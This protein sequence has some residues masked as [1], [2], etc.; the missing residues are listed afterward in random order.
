MVFSSY[1]FLFFFLPIVCGAY[2]ILPARARNGF[3]LIASLFFYGWNKPLLLV[4]LMFSIAVNYC[5]GR[6]VAA[7]G[8]FKKV[9]LIA[10]IVINIVLLL[11]YKYSNFIVRSLC[12]LFPEIAAKW[13]PVV[14]P[15]GISFFTFQ[16]MSYTI[17]VYR[18][19][20]KALKNPLDV[21]LYISLF[22]QL[23]AGPIVRFKSIAEEIHNRTS[24][25][26][27]IGCGFRRFVYGLS[28]K[29]ILADTFGKIADEIFSAPNSWNLGSAWIGILAYTFQIYYDFSGYSDM[30][31]G[32]GSVFGFHFGENFNFPYI[33][34][35]ITEFWHRW[36]ISLST[37]F[38]DYVYIPLGGSRVTTRRHIFNIMVVWLLTG[39]WHGADWSFI[40]WGIYYG[41]LLLV[42]KYIIKNRFSIIK[43][44]GWMSTILLV[45][46]G[47][48]LFRADTLPHAIEYL[49]IMFSFK[50]TH[51]GYIIFMRRLVN[52]FFFWLVGL[53]GIFP[54]SNMIT[55]F[56][57]EKRYMNGV[58]YAI[59]ENFFVMVLFGLSI[60]T[61]IANNYNAFIYFQF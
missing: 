14:L 32:L 52:Y 30:A 46:I 28:K 13:V 16:G 57:S 6:L 56:A 19:D 22:P 4:V 12:C 48:V 53:I 2:F 36:H 21:A 42:E 41:V 23:V 60:I 5:T 39:A 47:W 55:D 58:P 40:V 24:T 27:M 20:V 8:R 10:G 25:I 11:Y 15:L 37:W 31:I 51:V 9:Y 50:F 1:V 61:L 44:L 49:K 38:R 7:E 54:V 3:L 34:T 59:I 45:M 35:S 18:G 17:D 33:S 26:D 29:I 43:P